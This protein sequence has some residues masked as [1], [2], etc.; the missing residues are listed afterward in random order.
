MKIILKLKRFWV[1]A[2]AF[3]AG[4]G[5]EAPGRLGHDGEEQAAVL[6]VEEYLLA[7]IAAQ[8]DVIETAGQVD[9]GFAGHGAILAGRA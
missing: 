7:A 1:I 6:G 5:A 4:A 3:F 2:A 9:A 8:H